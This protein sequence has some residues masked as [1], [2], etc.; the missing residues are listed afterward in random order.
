M[1]DTRLVLYPPS[2]LPPPKATNRFHQQRNLMIMQMNQRTLLFGRIP[3]KIQALPCLSDP[4]QSETT[5]Q[6]SPTVHLSYH[7]MDIFLL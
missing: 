2:Q 3:P 6:P 5:V 1:L 7:L 4:F